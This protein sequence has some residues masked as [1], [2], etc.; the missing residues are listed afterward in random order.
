[1][2]TTARGQEARSQEA[3]SGE[4]AATL[5]ASASGASGPGPTRRGA[6]L[7][8]AALVAAVWASVV[9]YAPVVAL[10][11][12]GAWGSGAPTA[13][14]ARVSAAAWLLAHGVPV[15]TPAGSITLVPLALTVLAV[16]RVARAGVHA[17]RAIGGHR[18][19]RLGRALAAGVAVGVAYAAVGGGLAA[20][21][22]SP[23]V[24]LSPWRAAIT[25][26]V[27][28]AVA[29]SAGALAHAHA[30]AR[31]RIQLAVPRGVRDAARSGTAAV[32]LL[33]AAG[34][35]AAGASLAVH[36]GAAAEIL[37]SYQAGVH[38]QAG[39]TVLCLVYLPNLAIWAA[40]YV[41]GPGF[42]VGTA[43][44]VSPGEVVLGSLPG[45]PVFAALPTTGPTGAAP[46]LLAVPLLVGVA[47]GAHQVRRS[48]RGLS[49]ARSWREMLVVV[50]LV[51]PVAGTL[52]LAL[53]WASAGALGSDRLATLGP[54]DWRIGVLTA[55]VVGFGAVIGAALAA[56]PA[57]RPPGRGG[58]RP[59]PR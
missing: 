56:L 10:A 20:V 49:P 1:M 31:K 27:F 16:W 8:L 14:V 4:H 52:L 18:H 39:I 42:A 35:T 36:G 3:R 45:L 51:G 57:R 37:G 26:G 33:V 43:T 11:F 53:G 6:P 34:A 17:S 23:T 50:A 28:G 22:G 7:P 46:V 30:R 13:G 21:A 58:G 9:S 12:L 24:G 47:V 44:I 15:Q 55:L 54:T 19:P 32:A 5:S 48:L 41:L 40:A 2:S 38:G 25:L 29:A 59:A